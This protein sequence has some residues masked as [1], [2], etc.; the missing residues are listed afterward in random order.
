MTVLDS[1]YTAAL[2]ATNAVSYGFLLVL[3]LWSKRGSWTRTVLIGACTLTV[4]ASAAIALGGAAVLGTGGALAELGI[5]GGWYL[6]AVHIVRKQM[7]RDNSWIS[8]L[9]DTVGIALVIAVVGFGVLSESRGASDGNA[10]IFVAELVSR[11]GLSVY[12]V[13]LVENIYR[14][15]LP[16]SRWHVNVLCV[17]LG[18]MFAV[19]IILY[20]DSLLFNRVSPLLWSGRA[21]AMTLALPL[22]VVA[23]VRN[24]DWKIDIHVSRSVVFHTATLIS[25]GVFLLALALTGEIIRAIE[26]GWGNLA[27]V[28]LI[29]AGI[30]II[31]V[32]AT[33]GG[34]RSRLRRF[35]ADNLYSHR[36][37]YRREWLRNIGI[38]A[39]D[40]Q[41]PVQ[42]RVIKAVAEIA[43][44]PAGV[45]WVRDLNT[46]LFHWAG[47]WNAPAVAIDEPAESA[48]IALFRGGGWVVELDALNAR[49][50]WLD[51]IKDA[52]L[53]IPLTQ[54]QEVIGFIVLLRPRA[55]FRLDRE[56]FDLLRIVGRQAATHVAEQRFAQAFAETQELRDFAKRFAFVA[57][58]MKNVASQLAMIVQNAR[59]H[60]GDAE[61]NRDVLA[62]VRS[63]HERMRD[64]LTTLRKQREKPLGGFIVPIDLIRDELDAIQRLRGLTIHLEHDGRTAVVAMEAAAFRSVITHLC[65]NA[66]EASSGDVEVRVHHEALRVQIEVADKGGGMSAEFVRDNLFQPF[67]ST[68]GDGL[69][70]GAFQARELIRAAG[71]DLLVSSCLGSGTTMR[72]LLP[73]VRPL[74]K[75]SL[76]R[77]SR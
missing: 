73:C 44:S 40:P 62:T 63:A 6:V 37:D 55:P 68:K 51:E 29:L 1:N 77:A 28:T 48:F 22:F 16:E 36:Y 38:L 23:I 5:V 14:N 75:P 30:A 42:T 53:G 21:I 60:E 56:T 58:D 49:P 19:G 12:G 13:W 3:L 11:L 64:L 57:H 65:A 72:I 35:V 76:L 34:G 59:Y 25:S 17:G 52:W 24:R 26:P 43:D 9:I 20:S 50:I 4:G 41:D 8:Y 27:E 32:M 61:F 69:G 18:E 10:S 74:A 15:T 46:D 2:Y 70:I 54:R 67:G 7:A 47:S 39:A 33:S 45:L 66:I 71:G 31:G